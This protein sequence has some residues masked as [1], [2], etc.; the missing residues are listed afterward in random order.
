MFSEIRTNEAAEA[1]LHC[2]IDDGDYCAYLYRRNE[3]LRDLTQDLNF[4]QE[5]LD[6]TLEPSCQVLSNRQ[7]SIY[8]ASSNRA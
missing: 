1:L 2:R 4:E 5:K 6:T 8:G 3:E 7:A